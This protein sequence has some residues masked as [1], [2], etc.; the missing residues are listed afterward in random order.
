MPRAMLN[1][2]FIEFLR[3]RLE[4]LPVCAAEA[5]VDVRRIFRD[6]VLKRSPADT[7]KRPDRI[8]FSLT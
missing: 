7:P 6:G 1:A 8:Q 3:V 2:D 4:A 5:G